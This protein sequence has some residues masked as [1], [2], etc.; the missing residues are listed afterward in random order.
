MDADLPYLRIRLKRYLSR[1]LKRQEDVEDITQESFFRVLQAGST[2]KIEFPAAYLYRTAR[3]LALNAMA[4]KS[5]QLETSIEDFL[6]QDV[7]SEQAPLED[8][9]AGQR[10][11]EQFCHA[12]TL[13]PDQCRKVL[14]LRKVYGFSQQ[15]VA[16][17]L[18]ISVSTVE[19][20]L[21]K[22]LVRCAQSMA[23]VVAEDSIVTAPAQHNRRAGGA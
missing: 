2:G 14:I 9:L 11:F 18:G 4:R 12:A 15:E 5:Y 17:R 19:K 8:V 22:A 23:P 10:R 3:N 1:L 21:A 13:L 7:L 20:H 6:G 16:D